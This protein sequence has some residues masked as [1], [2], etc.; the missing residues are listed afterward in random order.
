MSGDDHDLREE[1]KRVRQE[2]EELRRQVQAQTQQTVLMMQKISALQQALE[3]R[4]AAAA[5]VAASPPPMTT[6]SLM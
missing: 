4:L 3:G 6:A 5:A 2:N 1:I